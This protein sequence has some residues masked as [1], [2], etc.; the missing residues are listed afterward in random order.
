MQ[1]LTSIY[2][3]KFIDQMGNEIVLKEK[4]R[5]IISLVPSQTE[6]LHYLGLENEVIGITKF[7]IHPQNWFK[8]KTRIGGTK[9]IN[10][11]KIKQ[12]KPDLII[13][14]KEENVQSQIEELQKYFPVWMS[15]IYSLKDAYRMIECVGNITDKTKEANDLVNAIQQGFDSIKNKVASQNKLVYLIW[16]NP[17]ISVGSNTFINYILNEIGFENAMK[18]NRYPALTS[19]YLKTL[20]PHF[21][22]LSSEPFPF[23]EKHIKELQKN[24]PRAK[25]LLVDGEMFS[26]YGSR[27]LHA[28]KYF[29]E[30]LSE[31]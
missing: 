20:N 24:L 18:E 12:L 25:I 9:T 8:T 22:F 6:L 1:D 15:D 13:G 4:P 10:I 30:L 31:L 17:L 27:L 29:I 2:P 5:R 19:E 21:I 28:P 23:K 14:N 16:N 26:W 7:C 11:E 3:K